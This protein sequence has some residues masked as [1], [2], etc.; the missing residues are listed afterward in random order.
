[1]GSDQPSIFAGCANSLNLPGKCPEMFSRSSICKDC[2]IFLCGWLAVFAIS[3]DVL[4]LEDVH[5]VRLFL[6]TF[7]AEC[8]NNN[9]DDNIPRFDMFDISI[10]K[11]SDYEFWREVLHRV[12]HREMP[13]RDAR[14]PN[15]EELTRFKSQVVQRLRS[16]RKFRNPQRVVMRRLNRL[17]YQNTVRDLVGIEYDVA[18]DFPEDPPAFGFDNVG[19]ALSTSPLHVEKYLHAARQ[20]IGRAIFDRPKPATAKWRFELEQATGGEDVWLTRRN[21]VGKEYFYARIFAGENPSRDNFVEIHHNAENRF[22]GVREFYVPLHGP[23]VIRVR[24]AAKI[25]TRREV[26]DRAIPLMDEVHKRKVQEE[27][28]DSAKASRQKYWEETQRD[29]LVK[30]FQTDPIYRYGP[31]RLRVVVNGT[32][33]VGIAEVSNDMSDPQ[34]F[35]FPVDVHQQKFEVK[36]NNDY[37]VP[38]LAENFH[39]LRDDRFPRP[40][41]YVDWLEIEGP[42]HDE[43]PPKSHR[44]LLGATKVSQ[45]ESK[46]AQKTIARFMRRAFRRTVSEEEIAKYYELYVR[47]RASRKSFGQAIQLPFTAVLASA[48][49]LYQVEKTEIGKPVTPDELINRLSYFLWNSMPDERLFDL[50]KSKQILNEDVLAAEVDRMLS[51]PKGD[52][53]A[54]VFAEQWLG[55]RDLGAVKPDQRIYPHFDEHLLNSIR[56]ESVLFFSEL[57]E[58]DESILK[59]IDADFTILNERLARF[60]KIPNVQGDHFRRV[61]LEPDS[62]RGGVLTQA[63]VLTVTSNGTRTSPVKRGVWILENILNSPTPP[64]P[65][66]VGDIQPGVP[67]IDKATVRDRLEAH[68]QNKACASCH[69]KID[70]LGF[71]LENYNAIGQ[72]R[73]KEGFGYQGAVREFDPNIDPKG[74]LPDG[75][76]FHGVQELQQLLLADKD[77]FVRCFVE[78]MVIYA[79]GRGVDIHDQDEID[80]IV[81]DMPRHGYSIRGLIKSIV[82]SKLFLNR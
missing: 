8:H 65:P 63:S 35:E 49:F 45:D 82:K 27:K 79:L 22:T 44:L 52:S 75:R 77:R 41:L 66:N 25:P 72:W 9:T 36:I 67:G 50:A 62:R 21:R 70:P 17:Q 4:A 29:H 28:T 14:Q 39:Y 55:I 54:A 47:A 20:I 19:S 59:F 43:W 33:A 38:S 74:A 42:I 48:D 11:R 6:K 34:V 1:M 57:L 5:D 32:T 76:Q 10:L 12:E 51:D 56:E 61:K 69:R 71:A 40:I 53:F 24:A 73:E 18:N 26:L 30:H 37:E 23:Y 46:H 58:N 15:S 81:D 3:T 68:R 2:Y 31:A 60:Y 16:G 80:Q 78:K 64:P 13:P 7:C